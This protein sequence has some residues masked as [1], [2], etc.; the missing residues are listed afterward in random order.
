MALKKNDI[1][2][3]NDQGWRYL[4][5]STADLYSQDLKKFISFAK[6]QTGDLKFKVYSVIY[7]AFSKG[8]LI[9]RNILFTTSYVLVVLILNLNLQS[10]R[11]HLKE[12]TKCFAALKESVAALFLE[13]QRYCTCHFVT[14]WFCC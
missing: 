7:L 3:G 4:V 13:G 1:V 8:L 10:E 12:N 11:A 6:Y 14:I 5:C 9:Q 2:S